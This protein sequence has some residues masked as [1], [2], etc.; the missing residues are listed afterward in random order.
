MGYKCHETTL[1]N[2]KVHNTFLTIFIRHAL[3][4]T[5]QDSYFKLIWKTKAST[6]NDNFRFFFKISSISAMKRFSS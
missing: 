2:T 3:N 6:V 5:R 4:Q 1:P